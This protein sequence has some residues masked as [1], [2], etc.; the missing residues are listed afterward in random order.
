MKNVRTLTLCLF[1]VFAL[2]AVLAQGASAKLPEWGGCEAA[3][4][5]HGQVQ[6]PGL[7]RK[8]H[9]CREEDRRR[10]RMVHGRKLRLGAPA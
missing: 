9:G 8:G 7:P 2:G 3:A 5:G 1:A 4:P 6:G 10:L